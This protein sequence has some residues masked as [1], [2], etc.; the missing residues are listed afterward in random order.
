MRSTGQSLMPE[1]LEANLKPQDLADLL[2]FLLT[3]EEPRK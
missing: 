3:A 1:A 2:E